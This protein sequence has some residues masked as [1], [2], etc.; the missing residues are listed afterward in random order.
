MALV[1]H[2][3]QPE[4]DRTWRLVALGAAIISVVAFLITDHYGAVLTYN[5]SISHLQIARR[6]VIST[7]PGAAQLGGVWLPLPHVLTIPLV[8]INSLYYSGI[9]G[10]IV[11]MIANVATVVLVYKIAYKLADSKFAGVT[12]ATVFAVNVN[13]LYM[14][15]TPMTESLLF[16]LLAGVI[17]CTQQ[18]ADTNR[19][20]YLV[21]T[22]ITAILA[23]LTRYESWPIVG[24][25]VVA[26]MLIAYGQGKKVDITSK[27]LRR[28]VI[29][30]V[31]M[32]LVALVVGVGGWMAWN[33]IIFGSFMNFQGGDYA[34]PSLW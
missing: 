5:D 13:V 19:A 27:L 10:S 34:K 17:Y 3:R 4:G 11:S 18:W 24:M 32:P 30:R 1:S 22:V 28:R 7:S 33:Q 9:A 31:I 8:W 16:C 12:A 23:L 2:R 6:V 21:G 15:S 29:D 14:Q 20:S 25:L 26:V